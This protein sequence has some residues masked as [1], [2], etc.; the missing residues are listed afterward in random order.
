MR[1]VPGFAASLV[2]TI[3]VSFVTRRPATTDAMFEAMEGHRRH[4]IGI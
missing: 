3:V 1:L 4:G 2:A